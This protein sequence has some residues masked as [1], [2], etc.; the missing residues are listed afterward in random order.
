M[1]LKILKSIP[2]FQMFNESITIREKPEKNVGKNEAVRMGVL[3]LVSL[4]A[5]NPNG[6]Q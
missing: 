6:A 4:T 5:N 2:D 3:H 1:L